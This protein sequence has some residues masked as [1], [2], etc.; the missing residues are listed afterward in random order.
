MALPIDGHSQN[1]DLILPEDHAQS[2]GRVIQYGATGVFAVG[3]RK[4]S[5]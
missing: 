3:V 1:Q 2:R 4:G 5:P